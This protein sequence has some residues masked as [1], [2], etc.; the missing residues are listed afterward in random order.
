MPLLVNTVLTCEAH[1]EEL[2]NAVI[3][4]SGIRH[5]VVCRSAPHRL[6]TDVNLNAPH[7]VDTTNAMITT[8]APII[9]N[10]FLL[11]MFTRDV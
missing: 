6:H 7:I 9:R 11:V 4:L 3:L 8:P 10:R 5:S 2:L 1:S